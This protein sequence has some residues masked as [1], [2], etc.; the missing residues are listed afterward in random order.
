MKLPPVEY[1][2]PTTAAEAV[3]LLAE[4]L[5]EAS[6]LAAAAAALTGR[7]G[8]STGRTSPR[9]RERH[10]RPGYGTSLGSWVTLTSAARRWP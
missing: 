7:R 2:A 1:K 3:D 5:D 4:H 9:T 8:W 6:V 10:S